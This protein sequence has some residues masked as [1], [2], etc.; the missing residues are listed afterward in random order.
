M[1]IRI[2]RPQKKVQEW[3][4]LLLTRCRNSAIT[5]HQNGE[6]QMFE[7]THQE[8]TED[9]QDAFWGRVKALGMT[10]ED[11]F[12]TSAWQNAFAVET[13][14]E[15]ADDLE[16]WTVALATLEMLVDIGGIK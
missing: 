10:A 14:A 3:C 1:A 5:V 16:R 4:R 11:D 12:P 6:K 2:G 8:K 9:A 15:Y 7:L 13:H